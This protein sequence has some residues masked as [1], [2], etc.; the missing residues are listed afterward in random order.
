MFS[1][2]FGTPVASA[3]L[4]EKDDLKSTTEKSR[5]L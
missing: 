3:S 1:I 2:D 5:N 4:R